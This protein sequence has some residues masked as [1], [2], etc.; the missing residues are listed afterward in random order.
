MFYLFKTHVCYFEKLTY[1]SCWE[2]ALRS[3]RKIEKKLKAVEPFTVPN[4]E[5]KEKTTTT[6]GLRKVKGCVGIGRGGGARGRWHKPA[7]TIASCFGN[8]TS[9]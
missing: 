8:W 5:E 4:T 3:Y 6:I 7:S 1:R 9:Y 2:K